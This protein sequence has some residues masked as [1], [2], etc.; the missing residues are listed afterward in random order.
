MGLGQPTN[1]PQLQIISFTLA[2]SNLCGLC[3]WLMVGL[4]FQIAI[5]LWIRS[6]SQEEI[7]VLMLVDCIVKVI[8]STLSPDCG[9]ETHYTVDGI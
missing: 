2:G 4:V 7:E 5:Y 3:L 9:L 8:V 6:W 1:Q